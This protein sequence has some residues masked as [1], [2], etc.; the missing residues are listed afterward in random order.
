MISTSWFFIIIFALPLAA[1]LLY[2][3]RQDR[4]KG[5][6]GVIILF[7]LI[8]VAAIVSSKASKNAVNNFEERK[9]NA[10]EVTSLP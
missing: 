3:M 6:W 9:K 10:Q 4:R 5:I 8:A 1:L 7:I 2:I